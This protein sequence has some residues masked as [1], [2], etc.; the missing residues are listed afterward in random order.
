MEFSKKTVLA[1]IALLALLLATAMLYTNAGRNAKITVEYT[2][3]I[4]EEYGFNIK[5]G[6][7]VK[8]DEVAVKEDLK[9]TILRKLGLT[10]L[11]FEEGQH[12][13]MKL[14]INADSNETLLGLEYSNMLFTDIRPSNT[15]KY[16]LVF[17][18]TSSEGD[19]KTIKKYLLNDAKEIELAGT[20]SEITVSRNSPRSVAESIRITLFNNTNQDT[21]KPLETV[22]HRIVICSKWGC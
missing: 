18:Y 19:K 15:K 3:L 17:T 7:Y 21:D 13:G 2:R 11:K 4:P 16:P 9:T 14:K 5:I 1:L 20:I 8:V 12:F 6:Q 22:N 10:P